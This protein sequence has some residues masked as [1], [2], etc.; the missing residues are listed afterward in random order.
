MVLRIGLM[1]FIKVLK[2]E[3]A[4]TCTWP[5]RSDH[6]KDERLDLDGIWCSALCPPHLLFPGRQWD[7]R[8]EPLCKHTAWMGIS[9]VPSK[10]GADR[11][12]RNARVK[13]SPRPAPEPMPRP[14]GPHLSRPSPLSLLPDFS[15]LKPVHSFPALQLDL[16]ILAVIS[17]LCSAY[18]F[19]GHPMLTLG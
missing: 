14:Q 3:Q 11:A 8:T 7:G 6:W 2:L 17:P 5:G 9:V 1:L 10:R 19:Q 13:S 12:A 18:K 15:L 4:I 16:F